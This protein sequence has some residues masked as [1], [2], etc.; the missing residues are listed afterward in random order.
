[1]LSKFF[2]VALEGDTID[3]RVIERRH[4]EEMAATYDPVNLYNA[5]VNLEHFRGLVPGGPFD[6]LGDVVALEAREETGKNAGKLGLYAQIRAL[7]KLLEMNRAGQKLHSSIEMM[8][9]FARTGKAYLVGLAVTDSPA[10]LGTEMLAFGAGGFE[11]IAG[12]AHEVTLE[13]EG[14]EDAKA[15]KP[16]MFARVKDMLSGKNKADAAR[17]ADLEAS[18]TEIAGAVAEHD[19]GT[20]AIVEKLSAAETELAELKAAHAKL[21]AEFAALVERLEAE[22]STTHQQ[23]QPAT[24]GTGQIA[25]DC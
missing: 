1:M 11:A 23:R 17:F 16:S 4:I 8:T 7:P 14:D 22:P 6:A 9:N 24:G 2:R 10:S 18:I 3:G 19:R 12:P 15:E 5:R 20:D 21:A 25:T 13:F